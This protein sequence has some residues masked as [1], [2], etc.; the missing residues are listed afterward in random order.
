MKGQGHAAAGHCR[1][2]GGHAGRSDPAMPRQA[3]RQPRLA[4]AW[5]SRFRLA[6]PWGSRFRRARLRLARP[7]SHGR[8]PAEFG[9]AR[10]RQAYL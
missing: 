8:S 3:V 6:M 1:D 9:Q 10:M 7:A 4:M 5:G 2:G